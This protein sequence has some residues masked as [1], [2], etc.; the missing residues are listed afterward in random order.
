MLPIVMVPLIPK[1]SGVTV[2]GITILLDDLMLATSCL[3]G[4]LTLLAAGAVRGRFRIKLSPIS[5]VLACLIAYKAFALLILGYFLPWTDL[6]GIGKGVLFSEGVLLLGRL[7]ML[8]MVLVLALQVFRT[9]SSVEGAVVALLGSA[10]IVIALGL[11]QF[12]FLEH[13]VLTSTFRPIAFIGQ[14]FT[15]IENPWLDRFAS[16][17]EHLAAFCVLVAALVGGLL[18][19]LWQRRPFALFLLRLLGL[20]SLFVLLFSS[21]RGG[22]IGGIAAFVVFIVISLRTAGGVV[23]S[24]RLFA[25]LTIGIAVFMMA[26]DVDIGDYIDRRVRG[27]AVSIS[28]GEIVDD[29]ANQRIATFLQLWRV[30]EDYPLVGL[31]PGGAGRIAEGQYIRELVEGGV[32]GTTIFLFMMWRITRI[33]HTCFKSGRDR[34]TRGIGLGLLGC[35]AGFLAQ[36]LFTELFVVVKVATPFWI[37]VGL[38]ERSWMLTQ[39]REDPPTA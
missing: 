11:A 15:D 7:G 14:R 31:G 23:R 18:L 1:V 37:L 5:V 26:S 33:G 27:I 10:S 16:G 29:S 3:T 6:D 34:L 17:H 13:T 24:F 9:K 36:A 2:G 38:T 4:L 30:F 21:S 19:S 39:T 25:V 35:T 32:V 28:G 12:F 8:W 22:W 20:S